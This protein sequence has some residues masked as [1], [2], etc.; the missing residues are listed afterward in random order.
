[1]PCA[2]YVAGMDGEAASCIIEDNSGKAIVAFYN[3]SPDEEKPTT[4][5]SLR[6]NLKQLDQA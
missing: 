6:K 3:A 4:A 5:G 2:A 1:M